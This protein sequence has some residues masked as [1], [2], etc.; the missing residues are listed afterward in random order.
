MSDQEDDKKNLNDVPEDPGSE[1]QPKVDEENQPEGEKNQNVDTSEGLKE[2][3]DENNDRRISKQEFKKYASNIFS[4]TVDDA[5]F[6]TLDKNNGG[7]ILFYEFVH[8]F[9]S[10][11]LKR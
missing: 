6:D 5:L 3:I 1:N 4:E 2:S 7:Y 8:Y 11:K 9:V 10:K